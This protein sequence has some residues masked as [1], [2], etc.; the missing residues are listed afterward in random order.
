[1]DRTRGEWFENFW[2]KTVASILSPLESKSWETRNLSM[3]EIAKCAPD[4]LNNRPLVIGQPWQ[5][6]CVLKG[7]KSG[8]S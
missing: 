1:M 7:W 6:G 5:G 2:I 3:R 4:H 8:S